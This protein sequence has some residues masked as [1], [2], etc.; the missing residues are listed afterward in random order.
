MTLF[1][2]MY[3]LCLTRLIQ[4]LPG[5]RLPLIAINWLYRPVPWMAMGLTAAIAANM[6]GVEPGQR[7]VA[8]RRRIF[9]DT[10]PDPALPCPARL[11]APSWPACLVGTREDLPC[12][13]MPPLSAVSTTLHVAAAAYTRPPRTNHHCPGYPNMTCNGNGS[14]KCRYLTPRQTPSLAYHSARRI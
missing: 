7:G 12:L 5:P 1:T 14:A 9:L 2:Y 3:L 10:V 8:S 11:A 6:P 13:S 4:Q